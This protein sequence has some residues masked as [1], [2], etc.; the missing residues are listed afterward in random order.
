MKVKSLCVAGLLMLSC[1]VSSLATM[2]TQAAP[3]AKTPRQDV[4]RGEVYFLE[5]IAL[6]PDAR[7]HVA[8]VGRVAG[9]SYLPIA[10]VV[11]A[12]RNGVTPFHIVLPPA[13]LRPLPPYRVQAWIVDKQRVVMIGHQASTSITSLDKPIRVRLKV[14]SESVSAN[15][16]A[17]GN[18]NEPDI[19]ETTTGGEDGTIG[20][21][22]F[23]PLSGTVTKRDRRALAP[24]A[25]VVVT[26]SDVSR[27]DAPAVVLGRRTIELKGRQLPVEWD[28]GISLN[29][30]KPT[31]RY[32]LRAQVYEDGKLSYTTDS[33][34]GVTPENAGES[35]ELLVRAAS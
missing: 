31:G 8:L 34:I 10:S 30:L 29:K 21:P 14:A 5:R 11:V 16:P 32:A 33:F 2:P 22:A 20:L 35:R 19:S 18:V 13:N 26:L 15:A 24:D 4:L 3:S 1:A 23:Y 17:G 27:A 6:P 9:A 25:R 12:A 7:L 28:F